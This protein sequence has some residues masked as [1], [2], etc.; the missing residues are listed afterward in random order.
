M[1]LLFYKS[2]YYFGEKCIDSVD[3]FEYYNILKNTYLL[4]CK[5]GELFHYLHL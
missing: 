3:H 5:E 4:L 1:V 2:H